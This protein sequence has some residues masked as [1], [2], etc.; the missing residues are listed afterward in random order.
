LINF[1]ILNLKDDYFSITIDENR[2]ITAIYG[3]LNTLTHSK[4]LV[5][6]E[7]TQIIASFGSYQTSSLGDN[8]V[9]ISLVVNGE[10]MSKTSTSTYK[11]IPNPT[12]AQMTIGS[13]DS[14]SFEGSVGLIEIYTP[15]S[16]VQTS[17]Y[18]L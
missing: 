2:K 9:R 4:E 13:V 12:D 10:G 14:N 1:I 5:V 8:G 17:N 16:I 11:A 7:W 6:S 18:I 3:D 15:G